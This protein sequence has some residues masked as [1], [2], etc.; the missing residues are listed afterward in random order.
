MFLVSIAG[1][2]ECNRHNITQLVPLIRAVAPVR[3]RPRQRLNR[4]YDVPQGKDQSGVPQLILSSPPP[5]E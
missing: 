1:A 5:G 3:G 4:V 2:G